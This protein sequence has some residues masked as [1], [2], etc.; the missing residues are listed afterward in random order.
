MRIVKLT[1]IDPVFFLHHTQLDRLW[2]KWQSQEGRAAKY[3]GSAAHDSQEQ[4]SLTD[5]IPM[6]GLA[7]DVR[8]QDIISTQAGELCYN[9]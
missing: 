3:V 1:L 5:L 9:Y 6:G 8:V 7:P 2:S 4:A